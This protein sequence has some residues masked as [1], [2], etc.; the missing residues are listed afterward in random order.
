[1]MTWAPESY[2]G[3]ETISV[4]KA[5]VWHPKYSF[6]TSVDYVEPFGDNSFK[7]RYNYSG[8]ANSFV[9]DIAKVTCGYDESKYPFD[10]HDC[11][12]YIVV[13]GYE[14]TELELALSSTQMD[15]SNYEESSQWSISST[16]M[17][18]DNDVTGI[19]SV[20][21][22]INIKRREKY[23]MFVKFIPI[24]LMSFLNVLVFKL[25]VDAGERV[26]FS[27]T[28]LLSFAVFLT[29]ITTSLPTG[30][31]HMA[32]I[33]YLLS[34]YIIISSIICGVTIFT[35][36]L[37][38]REDVIPISSW[39]QRIVQVANCHCQRRPRHLLQ[40]SN[41]LVSKDD[42]LKTT[43]NIN[44]RKRAPSKSPTQLFNI[45]AFEKNVEI[46]DGQEEEMNINWKD[47]SKC[48]DTL[49]I[50]TCVILIVVITTIY[51]IAIVN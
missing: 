46:D 24:L 23:F 50:Y 25:P 6:A 16:S 19:I 7:F 31:T 28:C 34:M 14:P 9:F 20:I 17:Q 1:M 12:F 42:K 15:L 4:D 33:Y 35:V 11:H 3:I 10:E 18:S 26:G 27:I 40:T 47:V 32:Y 43:E 39:L 36:R 22:H 45:N 37:Y 51:F 38:H 2:G 44:A 41:K 13:V 29:D 48:I 49:M 30:T 21:C 5:D 8:Q